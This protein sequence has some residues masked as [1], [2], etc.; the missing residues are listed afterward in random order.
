MSTVVHGYSCPYLFNSSVVELGS[1]FLACF[2]I[3]FHSVGMWDCGCYVCIIACIIRYTWE[4]TVLSLLLL[5]LPCL[6]YDIPYDGEKL[7]YNSMLSLNTGVI[8]LAMLV[9]RDCR[10]N[11]RVGRSK[12][13]KSLFVYHV[14]NR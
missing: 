6:Y 4:G 7:I 5:T 9:I 3:I 12:I 1:R 2:I 8:D 10:H 11:I 13:K 14:V